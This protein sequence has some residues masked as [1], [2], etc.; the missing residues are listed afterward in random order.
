MKKI[1]VDINTISNFVFF[2]VKQSAADIVDIY[3]KGGF[4][5]YD[6]TRGEPPLIIEGDVKLYDSNSEE[7]KEFLK[8]YEK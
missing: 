7:G 8:R 5:I 6:S 2:G 1:A 4:L 3:T